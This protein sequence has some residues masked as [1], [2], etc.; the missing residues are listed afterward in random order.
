M[1]GSGSG[2][3]A[4]DSS[5]DLVSFCIPLLGGCEPTEVLRECECAPVEA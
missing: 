5:G 3:M 1:F 4:G 2:D